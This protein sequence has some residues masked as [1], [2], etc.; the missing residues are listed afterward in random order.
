MRLG[1]QGIMRLAQR[2][3]ILAA[4]AGLAAAAV[5]TAPAVAA[6]TNRA[7]AVFPGSNG[8][9]AFQSDRDHPGNPGLFEI[10]VMNADGS[11]Q[12]RLTFSGGSM[13]S[14]SP[15]GRK[16]AFSRNNGNGGEIWVMNADGSD[17]IQLTSTPVADDISPTWSPD[18][19]KIAFAR[20]SGDNY[21]IWVMNAD[22]SNPTDITNNPA[23]DIDPS[24]SPDGSKIAFQTN[25]DGSP[26]IY[27]MNA[28]GSGLQ[29]LSNNPASF[30]GHPDWSPDG[31]KIAFES[32][33]DTPGFGV[34]VYV[35]NADG[36]GVTRLTTTHQD[37]MPAWSPDG[38]KIAFKSFRDLNDEIYIM[39]ADGS[40]ATRLTNNGAP[41]NTFPEDWFPSWQ[42][43]KTGDTT[44]PVITVPAPITANATS[45][46][47]AVVTYTV[48]ATD[49]DDAVASLKCAPASGAVL[50]IGKTQVTCTAV[51]THG[52]MSTA[53]F[54]VTVKGA[55]AQLRD[56][57]TA[58][59]GVGPG[60][61]LADKVKAARSYLAAGDLAD[62]CSALTA[63]LHEVSAQSGKSIP[64][65]H[66][67]T[68]IA[69][70]QRIKAVLAC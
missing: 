35:M 22:G 49:P 14:W 60:T 37:E 11:N 51:D 57:L 50:P 17:P 66:A 55:K 25:R 56:L 2:A 15:D 10:Y 29:D 18:G 13:P 64:P 7:A 54:T 4:M 5:T 12:T 59:T 70:S 32:N 19:S 3:F 61:S 1:K 39:N 44:P 65:D 45:P 20:F 40:G 46:S 47:G 62:A 24:W 6:N 68:L 9:I 53:S 41:G 26:Q 16:I 28:D 31:S 27:T 42:P 69:T 38:T 23:E 58:V 21:D 43:I 48:T 30:D 34:D 36:S 63:F 67:A 52:N 33:R 8:K